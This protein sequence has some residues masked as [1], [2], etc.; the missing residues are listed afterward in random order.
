[1]YV[2]YSLAR[3]YQ[4]S[5][6]EIMGTN[7]ELMLQLRTDTYGMRHMGREK[8]CHKLLDDGRDKCVENE[9]ALVKQLEAMCY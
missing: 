1:M 9:A 7:Y 4:N 6:R 5:A 8:V 2:P 3:F